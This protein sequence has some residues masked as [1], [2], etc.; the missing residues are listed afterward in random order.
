MPSA[1][2]FDVLT[3]LVSIAIDYVGLESRQ[4]RLEVHARN[5]LMSMAIQYLILESYPL[6]G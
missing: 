2:H 4:F 6:A 5:E 3:E 1:M